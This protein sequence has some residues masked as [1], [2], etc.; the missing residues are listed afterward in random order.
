MAGKTAPLVCYCGTDSRGQIVQAIRA[1]ATTLKQIQ[2]TTGAGIGDR[3]KELNPKGVC[4]PDILAI[5]KD[6][7]GT[8]REG[9]CSCPHCGPK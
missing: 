5:L 9:G 2:S 6:E 1:G 4:I 8:K 7:T 3:C